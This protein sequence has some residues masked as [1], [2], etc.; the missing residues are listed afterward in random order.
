MRPPLPALAL[1]LAAGP[2]LAHES[3]GQHGG[4]IADAGPYHL[5]LVT[6]DATVE[7]YILDGRAKPLPAAG[8]KGRATLVADG[9]AARI[10][11]APSE[12]GSR[13]TGQAGS[14]LPARPKGA[15]QVTAPDGATATGT[16][17]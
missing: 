14:P 11:L 2:A 10:P 6:R 5:E 17:N 9:K 7:L 3:G 16:F 8:F 4:R 13:L 15:V 1:L 12:D